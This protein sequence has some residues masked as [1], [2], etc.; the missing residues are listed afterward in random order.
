M[1]ISEIKETKTIHRPTRELDENGNRVYEEI[2]IE[3]NFSTSIEEKYWARYTAKLID[4]L[5]VYIVLHFVFKNHF[6]IT[7]CC[8]ILIVIVLNT[9]SESIFGRTLGKW[10]M[11]LRVV[12]DFGENPA[13]FQSLV[14]NSLFILT[15]DSSSSILFTKLLK[16]FGIMTFF[17]SF[18]NVES[19]LFVVNE[20]EF[21]RIKK[22]LSDP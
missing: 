12:N 15:F 1:K 4:I 17:T 11:N 18:N 2:T 16:R 6:F 10:I 14:R 19:K 5:P 7:F 22:H 8:S 9:I 3:Q 20:S 21:K 13:F